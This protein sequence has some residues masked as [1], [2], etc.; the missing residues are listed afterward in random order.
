MFPAASSRS[1]KTAAPNASRFPPHTSSDV[2]CPARATPYIQRAQPTA[3]PLWQFCRT[4]QG[5]QDT[6][7]SDTSSSAFIHSKRSSKRKRSISQSWASL[8]WRWDLRCSRRWRGAFLILGWNGGRVRGLHRLLCISWRGARCSFDFHR[9][10]GLGAWTRGWIYDG[11]WLA[12]MHI[13]VWWIRLETAGDGHLHVLLS[14][15]LTSTRHSRASERAQRA[16]SSR[17]QPSTLII[18]HFSWHKGNDLGQY[19]LWACDFP[20]WQYHSCLQSTAKFA[21][22]QYRGTWRY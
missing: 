12:R 6:A 15:I 22:N 19:P 4:S 10:G 8:S 16:L 20:L 17:H 13:L 11:G 2:W 21:P 5:I 1:D 18:H 3:L 14:R 9:G 7:N